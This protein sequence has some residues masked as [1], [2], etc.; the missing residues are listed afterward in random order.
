MISLM[1]NNNLASIITREIA[2]PSTNMNNETSR[3]Q[4]ILY[5]K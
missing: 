3:S 1:Y 2:A 4:L 5:M